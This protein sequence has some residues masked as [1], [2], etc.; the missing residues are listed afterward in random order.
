MTHAS[1]PKISGRLPASSVV[2]VAVVILFLSLFVLE[3]SHGIFNEGGVVAKSLFFLPP[4]L[5]LFWGMLTR[6]RW[7]LGVARAVAIAGALWFFMWGAIAVAG[8]YH[9]QHGP[10]WIWLA[11]VSFTLGGLLVAGFIGL[12]RPST[13]RHYGL[14]CPKCD[15]CARGPQAY[16]SRDI[17]CK[18]C[19]HTWYATSR[20]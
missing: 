17:H 12:G 9:D 6:R 10:V 5:A 15:E 20:K 11:C 13:A 8:Q 7:A 16:F 1:E 18:A 19:G 14:V 4:T 2:G 3:I